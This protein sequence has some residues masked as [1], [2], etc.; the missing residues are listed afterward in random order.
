MGEWV[1][2]EPSGAPE[3]YRVGDAIPETATHVT[4]SAYRKLEDR[5]QRLYQDLQEAIR[6]KRNWRAKAQR[7]EARLDG[8]SSSV[9]RPQREEVRNIGGVYYALQV[10]S[11]AARD[12]DGAFAEAKTHVRDTTKD[13]G[14][15]VRV[16][17]LYRK[18]GC[19]Y[20]EVW[21][22]M[23]AEREEGDGRR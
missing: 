3:L 23:E 10:I 9:P 15:A 22:Q 5:N 1:R 14:L 17:R 21:A 18:D 2:L 7:A 12:R 11:M 6:A 4:K 16:D 13:T 20:A 8:D 19:W